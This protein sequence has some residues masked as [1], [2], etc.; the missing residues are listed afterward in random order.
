MNERT[1]RSVAVVGGGVV[2]LSAALAF[3]HALPRARVGLVETPLDPAALADLMPS[4]LPA[5][6]RFHARLGFDEVDL[7]RRGIATHRL[8]TSFEQWSADEDP[9]THVFGDYGLPMGPIGFH[10]LWL[11]G[12]GAN[13]VL[14]YDRYAAA[15]ML[16]NAGRF[17]HPEDDPRSPLSTYRYALRLDVQAYHAYLT[18]AAKG[19]GVAI[20]AGAL[21]EIERREDGGIAALRLRDGRRI[22][23][24]LFV[25]CGGPSAPL[26]SALDDA[27]EDWSAWLPADR[28]L[29]GESPSDLP[30]HPLDKAAAVSLG[31][32]WSIPLSGRRAFGIA[33]AC[34][35]TD[36]ARARRVLGREDCAAAGEAVSLRPGRR[37]RPWVRNVLAIGDSATALDPLHG[38]NL[39]LAHSAI[40]RAIELL[41]GRDFHPLE[42][43][44]YVR[45]TALET[46]RVRDFLALHYLRS[47]R[48]EGEFWIGLSGRPLPESLARTVEQFGVRGR[49][50]FFEEETFDKQA[51]VAAMIG[52]GQRPRHPNAM[53]GSVPE[54]AAE[55]GMRDL[56][57]RLAALPGQLPPY[58]DYLARMRRS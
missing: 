15:A 54:A 3:A 26:L 36:E 44:E 55:G 4:T 27:F 35:Q 1:I 30:P 9:W 23:A 31:W 51:W 5:I 2:S 24:D 39:S 50:A 38:T 37:P 21:G 25:D 8:G 10:D 32:C 46:A 48:A 42:L 47:G 33:Y 13:G 45:R 56:A 41:P 34:G 52:L 29:I 17:V 49:I 57:E 28:L 19:A 6:A 12:R 11:R 16:G 40:E 58:S 22:E 53:A 43:A 18:D 20:A 14:P 7:V